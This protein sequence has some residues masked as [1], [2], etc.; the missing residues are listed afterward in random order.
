MKIKNIREFRTYFK[1]E[2]NE[3]R[4]ENRVEHFVGQKKTLSSGENV[5]GFFHI[6]H[7]DKAD[8]RKGNFLNSFLDMAKDSQVLYEFLQNAVDADSSHFHM[9]YDDDY[10]LVV[11]NGKPFDFEGVRSILNVGSSSKESRSEI[12]R[13]GLGFKLVHRLIGDKAGVEEM[14]RDNL[15]PVIFSWSRGEQ[16]QELMNLQHADELEAVA[17]SYQR[18]PGGDRHTCVDDDPWL[19][20]I[21]MTNFPCQPGEE[22]Y[23]LDYQLRADVFPGDELMQL[24]HW[25][26]K[27]RDQLDADVFGQGSLFFVKLGKGKRSYLEGENLDHGVKFS[28]AVLNKVAESSGKRGLCRV[29]INSSEP[30]IPAKLEFERITIPHESPEYAYINPWPEDGR[31]NVDIEFLFGYCKDFR[32]SNQLIRGFPNFY[33]FFPLESEVHHLNFILHSNAFYNGSHR[34]S[35][36]VGGEDN[37]RAEYGINERLLEVFAARLIDKLEAYKTTDRERFASIYATLLLCNRSTD[38]QKRWINAPLLDEVQ[39]YLRENVPSRSTAD[40]W[41]LPAAQVRLRKTALEVQPSEFGIS[42]V[43][44]FYWSDELLEEEAGL[45]SKSG[46][47]RTNPKLG[48]VAWTMRDIIEAL[49]NEEQWNR[50]NAWLAETESDDHDMYFRVLEEISA[51]I[52]YNPPGKFTRSF[53]QLKLFRFADRFYSLN[54]L[55]Q[56]ENRDKLFRLDQLRNTAPELEKIG[57]VLSDIL[58]TDDRLRRMKFNLEKKLPYLHKDTRLFELLQQALLQ[59]EAQLSPQ[60][61]N[62]FLH[63][64][65]NEF[66]RQTR[67]RIGELQLYRNTGG[68]VQPLGRL[69]PWNPERYPAWL[70]PYQIA[71]HEY[72]PELQ[73]DYLLDDAQLLEHIIYPK[74]EALTSDEHIQKNPDGFYD[75]VFELLAALP[76][77]FIRRDTVYDGNS[78]F[79]KVFT[80]VRKCLQYRN[81][82]AFLEQ[83]RKK[84]Y[85]ESGEEDLIPVEKVLGNLVVRFDTDRL[86]QLPPLD[87]SKILPGR[88][89]DRGL[90]D[91]VADQFIDFAS[92]SFL[93]NTLLR[94]R[95]IQQ[96][97]EIYA[98]LRKDYRMLENAHQLAFLVAYVMLLEPEEQRAALASFEVMTKAGPRR[99]GSR[100]FL[101]R[102]CIFCAPENILE[103][104][105]EINNLLNFNSDVPVLHIAGNPVLGYEPFFQE[106]SYYSP[107]LADEIE[108]DDARQRAI[109]YDI[110]SKWRDE[111]PPELSV[112]ILGVSQ[113]EDGRLIHGEEKL[114]RL[115]GFDP[116]SASF[117]AEVAGLPDWVLEWLHDDEEAGLRFLAALGVRVARANGPEDKEHAREAPD[118][119]HPDEDA[120]AEPDDETPPPGDE[121]EE[122][123]IEDGKVE[124]ASPRSA[125]KPNDILFGDNKTEPDEEELRAIQE[126]NSR[127][128]F[129]YENQ[130]FATKLTRMLGRQNSVWKGYVYHFTHLENAAR[131]LRDRTILSRNALMDSLSDFKD[132]SSPVWVQNSYDTVKDCARFYFR[133]L[134]P[135]QWHVEGLGRDQ[136]QDRAICPVPIFFRFKLEDVLA[137]FGDRCFVSNGS[138]SESWVEAENG[139]TFLKKFDF[140]NVYKTYHEV[141]FSTYRR[142]SQQEFVVEG[143]MD[144]DDLPV[145]IICSSEQDKTALINLAGKIPENVTRIAVDP[146]FYF[147]C[148]PRVVVEV[149]EEN[150]TARI[151][152]EYEGELAGY[153]QLLAWGP[154]S[155]E[156]I[157]VEARTLIDEQIT[158]DVKYTVYYV[159]NGVKWLVFSNL[160]L[161]SSLFAKSRLAAVPQERKKRGAINPFAA[162]GHADSE[163][164]TKRTEGTFTEKVSRFW[165]VLT[166]R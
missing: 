56:P 151:D 45:F 146:E 59:H 157:S 93:R 100:Y 106:G 165:G 37:A 32:Q 2:V 44:W 79:H 139:Y 8:I 129:A 133:P 145:E 98:E 80:L 76:E 103:G 26:N 117:G 164:D 89:A 77:I 21:L 61:K 35:L 122:Q 81:D 147:G 25:L 102:D 11:N 94:P 18:I 82:E 87:L 152:G 95:E 39:A 113:S 4:E 114:S 38:R 163:K 141:D 51:N 41:C 64:F 68:T 156:P 57:F 86:G 42:R 62:K 73:N 66:D 135:V 115:L 15:G 17:Q 153:L 47:E 124:P 53:Q 24:V 90:V 72:S 10:L 155:M 6:Y 104:Y 43:E 148:N 49:E 160:S 150:I 14:A 16:L 92:K 1:V 131:I 132:S 149:G 142:A 136:L 60:E 36:L 91:T 107:P 120:S 46:I 97:H 111:Q 5:F 118:D 9:Y 48:L 127:Y 96:Y 12:G 55:V 58:I 75:D 134:T 20:K 83:F 22:V 166:G 119:S 125:L 110:F 50:F 7:G 85:F 108:H 161:F 69:L 27:Y 105:A 158:S 13:F 162:N 159:E 74:W 40:N 67:D 30:I 71:E 109:F 140:D 65:I 128:F 3:L 121:Q 99:L 78:F 126:R 88:S 28:L 84:I 143:G 116:H 54:D 23:D 130:D 29:C 112:T 137:K 144:F 63:A 34:G 52:G 123:E 19:F 138:L 154:S 101:T 33:Q 31:E 70:H